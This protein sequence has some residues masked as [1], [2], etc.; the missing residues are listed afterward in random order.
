MI[1]FPP[2]QGWREWVNNNNNSIGDNLQNASMDYTCLRLKVSVA[3]NWLSASDVVRQPYTGC[4]KKSWSCNFWQQ[5]LM[6]DCIECGGFLW[7]KNIATSLVSCSRAEVVE[8]LGWNPCWSKAGSKCVLTMV[9]IRAS[10]TCAAGQSSEIGRYEVPR[11][12]SLPGLGIGMTIDDTSITTM[13][14]LQPIHTWHTPSLQLHSHT[15]HTDTPGFVYR[16]RWSDGEISWLVD[17]KRD[18]RTPPTNKGQWSGYTTTIYDYQISGIRH[19]VTESFK[20][21]V[22]YSI[23]LGT[24]FFRRNILSLSCPNAS[25]LL[26]LLIPVITWCV[27]NVTVNTNYFRFIY[28]DTSRVTREEVCLPS[29]Y[30]VNCLLK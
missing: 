5:Y 10:I 7:L 13:T 27:V 19:D 14:P 9:S 3:C 29:F 6:I 15:H 24:R 17:Q 11:E 2:K 26:Q 20:S 8:C 28:L 4:L 18:D 21:T 23:A 22:R 25:V 30:V 16:P 1:G 12:E